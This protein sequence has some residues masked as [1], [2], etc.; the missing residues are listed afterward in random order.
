MEQEGEGCG[1][2]IGCGT[3]V[4]KV[5]AESKEEAFMKEMTAMDWV[6]PENYA[7][8]WN[9]PPWEG[10]QEISSVVVYEIADEDGQLFED[11]ATKF[12]RQMREASKEEKEKE[13]QDELR[14]LAAKYGKK[15]S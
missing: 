9:T 6:D 1:Y 11:Y 10:D 15:L 12:E 7:A 3:S 14:R 13:E 8:D 2:T 5:E 4:S